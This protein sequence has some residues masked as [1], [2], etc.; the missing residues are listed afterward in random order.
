M[1]WLELL[2]AARWSAAREASVGR[3]RGG[4][5]G[6]HLEICSTWNIAGA[7]GPKGAVTWAHWQGLALGL[8]ATGGSSVPLLGGSRL[9][10]STGPS[11]RI[12][13]NRPP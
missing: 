2:R 6:T 13:S 9:D 12:P 7:G 1:F 10:V 11:A 4:G 3:F 8:G 5:M